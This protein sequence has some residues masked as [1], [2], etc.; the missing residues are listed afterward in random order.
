MFFVDR[1]Y[2]FYYS[3]YSVNCDCTINQQ[4]KVEIER[5]VVWYECRSYN[6]THYTAAAALDQFEIANALKTISTYV[7][8]KLRSPRSSLCLCQTGTVKQKRAKKR[9]KENR[10]SSITN[11]SNSSN[12]TSVALCD[13]KRYRKN[14]E[15]HFQKMWDVIFS[16]SPLSLSLP[17]ARRGPL[18][19]R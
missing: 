8:A 14:W 3:L 9:E 4:E 19:Y 13:A 1:D 11:G 10:D 16:K 5:D 6:G 2:L 15:R 7:P 17:L 12:N 18:R